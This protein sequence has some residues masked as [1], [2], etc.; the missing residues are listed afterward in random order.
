MP[1]HEANMAKVLAWQGHSNSTTRINA[2]DG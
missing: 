2:A 1:W